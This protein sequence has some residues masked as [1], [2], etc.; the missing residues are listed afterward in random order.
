MSLD[1]LTLTNMRR[2]FSI[3]SG[4]WV[5]VRIAIYNLSTRFIG[6]QSECICNQWKKCIFNVVICREGTQSE[7]RFC[8]FASIVVIHPVDLL[9]SVLLN[10]CFWLMASVN[11][12]MCIYETMLISLAKEYELEVVQCR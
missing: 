1:E 10:N 12:I 2:V 11:K 5:A 8:G 3:Q 9:F 4:F 6:Y 7:V